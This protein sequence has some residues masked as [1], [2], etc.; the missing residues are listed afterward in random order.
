MVL[1]VTVAFGCG[2]SQPTP[3]SEKSPVFET[4]SESTLNA[5]RGK[6]LPDIAATDEVFDS[7]LKLMGAKVEYNDT[8]RISTLNCG[9][10]DFCDDDLAHFGC[11]SDLRE[12][13]IINTV[14][15]DKVF[16]LLVEAK[17]LTD[18][19][20]DS[21][22]VTDTGIQ[23]L[24]DFRHLEYISL[25]GTRLTDRGLEHLAG[26]P[27]LKFVNLNATNI[28]P[29]ALV[30]LYLALPKASIDHDYKFLE[31]NGTDEW[32]LDDAGVEKSRSDLLQLLNEVGALDAENMKDP[33]IRKAAGDSLREIEKLIVFN[34]SMGISLVQQEIATR[35]HYWPVRLQFLS[36]LS[37]HAT[38]GAEI[39]AAADALSQM[40]LASIDRAF[41]LNYFQ[42]AHRLTVKGANTVPILLQIVDES[43]SFEAFLPLHAIELPALECARQLAIQ[44]DE[45]HYVEILAE[46]L[47]GDV[48]E[49]AAISIV[50]CLVAAATEE[51]TNALLN[52]SQTTPNERLADNVRR[53][54]KCMPIPSVPI[55]QDPLLLGEF[56]EAFVRDRQRIA[57]F[58]YRAYEREVVEIVRAKDVA[59]LKGLRRR[60]ARTVSDESLSKVHFL[61]QL[62]CRGQLKS[63]E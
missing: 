12:L 9:G 22:D 43:E 32:R 21:T 52:F 3:N 28:S 51:S 39:Q 18:L 11:L 26:M 15:T 37:Y 38:A 46:R 30:R 1:L 47:R 24:G 63:G 25:T 41:Y 61:S 50:A 60:A 44:M 5:A 40:E 49:K 35:E 13:R 33:A 48:D 42:V 45:R 16:D 31:I 53:A 17:Q 10:S 23:R 55:T 29:A 59:N 57:K 36:L 8:G 56:L 58:D 54:M 4:Q 27:T 62:I 7:R 34:N 2:F 19:C 20:L 14:V 6:A